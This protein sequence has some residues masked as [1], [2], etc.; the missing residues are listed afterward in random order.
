MVVAAVQFVAGD[1]WLAD[2]R[3]VEHK[4]DSVLIENKA[5]QGIEH[6]YLTLG[7]VVGG[8]L[9]PN[10][11]ADRKYAFPPLT[12]MTRMFIAGGDG[13][14]AMPNHPVLLP[15]KVGVANGEWPVE[16][17]SVEFKI[18]GIDGQLNGDGIPFACEI[19][20]AHV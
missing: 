12:E 5:P 15:L 10:P 2:V 17:A 3:E 9:Q 13:Q 20:R 14:E 1:Y 4:V 6:H 8:V 18:K 7:K 16:G 19:G 11:E